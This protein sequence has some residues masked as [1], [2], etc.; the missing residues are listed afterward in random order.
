MIGKTLG[1][2]TILSTLG[3]GGMGEVYL[4]E[5]TRLKRRVALKV[6]PAGAS[7]P[8]RLQRFRREAETVA[9]LSHPHIVTIH[10]VEED[11]GVHFIT[12]ELVEGKPLD[13]LLEHEPL[14]L[15]RVF[16]LAVPLA[17]A[18]AAAHDKGIVHRDLKPANVMVTP[19][20]HVKVLDFGLAKAVETDPQVL[21]DLELSTKPQ[22]S[23]DGLVMGTVPYMSPEQAQGKPVD[24]RSDIFSFGILLYEMTTGRRPFGGKTAAAVISSILKDTPAPPL[25][26]NQETPNH[27]AR[28]IRRCLEKDPARRYQTARDLQNDLRDLQ[29]EVEAEQAMSSSSITAARREPSGHRG[30]W[31]A[32]GILIG[33]AVVA[34]GGWWITHQGG[35]GEAMD[36]IAVLPFVN[37]SGDSDTE[38][39][40]DGVTESLID[41]LSE[42]P[43]LKIMAR[44][45]VF[46]YKGSD[47][48][49]QAI[50][51]EL[52]VAAV[53]SGRVDLR[54]GTL[55]IGTEL[56]HVAD[57]TQIWGDRFNRPM[58]DLLQLEGEISRT[59]A[60]KLE[61]ELTGTQKENLHR[62][63][64]ADP[65]AYRAYL[66]GMYYWNKRTKEDMERGNEMFQ[67]AIRLDPD[68]ALAYSGLANGYL[69]MAN[70]GWMEPGEA[71][72]LGK[73]YALRALELDP[74][75]A[76]AHAA[77]GGIYSEHEWDWARAEAEFKKALEL[78]PGYATGHQWY[79]EF[80]GAM[81]RNREAAAEA[82]KAL[83]LDPLSLIVQTIAVWNQ[84]VKGEI[85]A[86]LAGCRKIVDAN[87]GFVPAQF[88]LIQV[89]LANDRTEGLAQ[90]MLKL[91]R[92]T[93]DPPGI[94]ARI[95]KAAAANDIEGILRIQL[96]SMES[97]AD[98][99]YVSPFALCNL[100]AYL[101]DIDVAFRYLDEALRIRDPGV[102]YL[103]MHTQA[104]SSM[105]AD[106]RWQAVLDRLH[107]PPT[108]EAAGS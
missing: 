94:L 57:G 39:L 82:Q 59:L 102:I 4:A 27:L 8:E 17:G 47:K 77:L 106:P 99:A 66:K 91:S 84:V 35:P 81:L 38:Y 9:A 79:A 48:D 33:L 23:S 19:D 108:P 10:S 52:G 15:T 90:E 98:S 100:H 96:E 43:N 71:A 53:L 49:P 61:L 44:N 30:R 93:G 28:I 5:D 62:T 70:W 11:Q 56:I 16:E 88:Q 21:E 89:S 20:G 26:L 85:D 80:L 2:Y 6:L 45:T 25:E 50:G 51:K 60:D 14:P 24:T 92:M 58:D 97:K 72:K 67:E 64:A 42:L 103:R 69:V 87:P 7:D 78:K 46:R 12:M 1:H 104:P 29:R 55:V 76:E 75:I 41:R 105:K 37:S 74:T 36:S 65:E 83:E 107:F 54:Q 86:A 68:F 22:I 3:K 73:R 40:V 32:V 31:M 95:E 101:G 63:L 18:L 13:S 34:M